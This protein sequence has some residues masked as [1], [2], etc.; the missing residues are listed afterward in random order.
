MS[1]LKNSVRLI[2]NLGAAPEVKT[3]A[4]EKKVAK[5]SLATNEVY[6]NEKGEKV[7]ETYWHNIV[8]WGALA[9][10]AEK[11]LQKGCEVAVEGKLTNR[12][13]TDKDGIKRYVSEILANEI[14][15]I[16][17]KITG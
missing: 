4:N 11:L 14:L 1:N 16:G 12:S 7:Q 15:L 9:G 3:V 6:K 10:I 13:Y 17:N 5:F 8:A 2:G